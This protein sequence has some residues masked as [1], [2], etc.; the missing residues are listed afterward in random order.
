MDK[1]LKEID[2]DSLSS[3]FSPI[4]HNHN[5]LY[6]FRN[7]DH[8]ELYSQLNHIHNDYATKLELAEY[9]LNTHNHDNFCY[10]L[11][12]RVS[13]DEYMYV[14]C[15]IEPTYA[16]VLEDMDGDIF[17]VHSI[18]GNY[19]ILRQNGADLD[20]VYHLL[21][22]KITY[23][24]QQAVTVSINDITANQG[25]TVEILGAINDENNAPVNIGN[26][27]Y[28]LWSED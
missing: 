8:N 17:T 24:V 27:N 16:T 28:S 2:I 1:R 23:D 12:F 7:H 9:S 15:P 6:S 20:K 11:P 10:F 3:L 4:N 18:N 14:N 19:V 22:S 25:D 21:F 26:V 13:D 5:N